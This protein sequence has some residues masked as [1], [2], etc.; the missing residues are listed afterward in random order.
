MFL[1]FAVVAAAVGYRRHLRIAL[2]I[3]GIAFIVSGQYKVLSRIMMTL[4]P[5]EYIFF[6]LHN[7]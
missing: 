7:Q 5:V 4:K 1:G 6:F 3:S 2:F